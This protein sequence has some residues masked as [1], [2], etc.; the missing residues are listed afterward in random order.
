MWREKGEGGRKRQ[1]TDMVLM[2]W[3]GMADRGVLWHKKKSPGGG[4]GRMKW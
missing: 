1:G 2:Q 3:P 4:P